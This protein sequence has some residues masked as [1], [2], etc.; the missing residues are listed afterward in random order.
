MSG[1]IKTLFLL[2]VFIVGCDLIGLGTPPTITVEFVFDQALFDPAR[3]PVAALVPRNFDGDYASYD[4]SEG[5]FEVRTQ[6]IYLD[7]INQVSDR[8]S[9]HIFRE[10]LAPTVERIELGELSPGRYKVSAGP[11]V[12]GEHGGHSWAVHHHVTISSPSGGVVTHTL[13]PSPGGLLNA[14]LEIEREFDLDYGDEVVW[15]VRLDRIGNGPCLPGVGCFPEC[16]PRI[17]GC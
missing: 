1:R 11:S 9:E 13:E 14:F 10:W 16:H 17:P 2:L 12:V 4:L 6:A 8:H 15:T 3:N 5:P 7:E